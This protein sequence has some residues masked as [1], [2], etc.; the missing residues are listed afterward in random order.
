MTAADL[1]AGPSRRGIELLAYGDRLRY[2]PWLAGSFGH[3]V[4][5]SGRRRKAGDS[6]APESGRVIHR[7]T[8]VPG[9][10]R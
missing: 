4:I 8:K 5:E 10:R 3:L 2:R 6:V 1:L 9:R 7:D